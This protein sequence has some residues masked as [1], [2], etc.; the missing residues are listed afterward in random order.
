MFN[1]RGVNCKL[2]N[3]MKN[4]IKSNII[5]E[6]VFQY[7]NNLF[8]NF[9]INDKINIYS[10]RY[11]GSKTKLISFIK[12][13]VSEECDDIDSFADI[14]SGTGVVANAFNDKD[15]KIIVNDI[16]KSNYYSFVS[17]FS[18]LEYD[19][20][21]VYKLIHYFNNLSVNKENYVSKHF[22]DKYFT[23]SNAKLIGEIRERISK[24]YDN[25][26]INFREK[27]ILITSLVYALDKIANTCGHYDAYRKKLDQNKKLKMKML[28]IKENNFNNN[29]Y[30]MD[31]N[32]LVKKI[33]AD[34]V[35]IDPPYNS[36][37]Y[38]DTYHLLE[39]IVEWNKPEVTGL[40]KKMKD[41]SHIKSDYCTVKAPKAFK[42]LIYNINSKY[43]LVSYSNMG[44]KGDGRSQAKISDKEIIEALE[45]KGDIKIFDKDYQYFTTGKADIEDHKERIF[46]C[47]VKNSNRKYTKLYSIK[48]N[49]NNIKSPLNYT[50]GKY[51]LLPQIKSYFPKNIN[52]F[53]D[54]FSGGANVGVNAEAKKIICIDYQKNI[55]E[56]FNYFKN[57]NAKKVEREINDIINYYDLSNTHKYSYE[58]YNTNSSKGLSE[59]NKQNFYELREDYNNENYIFNKSIM[60]YTLVIYSF[61]NQIR[62]NNDGK[63]NMPV[64]KRDFNS[65]LRNRLRNFI[66]K[67]NSKNIK[68]IC[69]D[70]RN[71][72]ISNLDSND[73]IYL[74]PPY[75]ISTASYNENGGW[76]EKDEND[77]Y[78]LLNKI[79]KKDIKFA[80]S[81]VL[82]H[83]DMKNKILENWVEN[84]DYCINYLKYNYKNSNYQKLDKKSE[85]IEVL[86]TNY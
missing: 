61:N 84:N 81:N 46:F 50:G 43:I 86:V 47:K 48:N 56:L 17:W 22:G 78:D 24:M 12:R 42:D 3:L 1:K 14:F 16:L 20:E 18:N 74:D 44:E 33:N 21:K 11:L 82:V 72:D 79:N 9:I 7:N 83:K 80:L 64:N 73:F 23:N 8:D 37:Q 54:V 26:L 52:I 19:K 45:N 31:A 59:Y 63:Y 66:E 27:C 75:L 58:Y 34:V 41:R 40:A 68:F 69:K 39:N 25:N 15:T 32:L 2:N 51:K 53:Y 71:F 70:F 10:R 4:H 36:R 85:S 65:S 30:N 6:S 55:I 60:F 57:K 35:Y 77:L 38:S 67:I 13:I 29:I 5:S 28:N 62:F 49:D 76:T